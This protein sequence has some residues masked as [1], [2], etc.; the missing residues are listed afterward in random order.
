MNTAW[1]RR[2]G[3]ATMA[4]LGTA[5]AYM[6]WLGWDQTYDLQ[7]DGSRTGP[8]QTWQV[9]GLTLTIG[10]LAWASALRHGSVIGCLL[11]TLTLTVC[12]SVDAATN[13]EVDGLWIIGAALVF[14]GSASGTSLTA[15]VA[16]ATMGSRRVA[17]GSPS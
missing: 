2:V 3:T 9:L 8:Y 15:L 13:A 1:R 6:A 7:P 17:S 10:A 16:K 12:W 14:I 5:I 11:I 4:L